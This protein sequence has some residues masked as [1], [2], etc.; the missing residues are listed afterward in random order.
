MKYLI[1][2]RFFFFNYSIVSAVKEHNTFEMQ[3][4]KG[5]RM[6]V[7]FIVLDQLQKS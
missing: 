6:L 5:H 2:W 7:F 3:G 1:K 4:Q